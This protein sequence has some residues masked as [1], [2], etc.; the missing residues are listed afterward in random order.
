MNMATLAWKPDWEQA[1]QA[2]TEWWAHRGL[3]LSITAPRVQ[4]WKTFP[5]KPKQS[6]DPDV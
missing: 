5:P 2:H 3:A 4:P 6:D 1:R